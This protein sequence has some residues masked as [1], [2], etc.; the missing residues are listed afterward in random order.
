MWYVYSQY[1]PEQRDQ[2]F[3]HFKNANYSVVIIAVLMSA[4]S[5]L[6]RAYRWSFMLTPLGYRPQLANNFMA[7][8]VSYLMNLFIP[9][10]GEI[11]RAAVLNK[12][13]KVPFEKGFGTIISERIV[14]LIF[15]LLFTL[16][17]LFLKFDLL[18]EYLTEVVPIK[19]IGLA[20]G[21]L[22]IL[23]VLFL[24]FLKYSKGAFSTKIKSL[25]TGLKSGIFSILKMEKKGLFI[26]C[27][28]FIWLL[29]ISSFYVST[30]A[31]EETTGIDLGVV[32]ITFVVGS[33]TFAFTNSGFGYYQLA[34]A[35]IL[36]VFGVP[37]TV[38]T[39]LGWIVWA[40]NI[41][42]IL[43]SG[44]LS[45]ILLPIYNRKRL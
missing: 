33:F 41:V 14:D 39:A 8:S 11:S 40:S 19:K 13:E 42:Y 12:Y 18:Y 29:Y 35:G 23:F 1:T 16:I 45:F 27:S 30:F 9:K 7:V 2:V 36:M 17:A 5:H 25:F 24:L 43:I 4:L 31:L 32:I 10:S 34:I 3:S 38:G 26:L 6:I 37:E 22:I 15:L 28:L 44:G 21:V 20:F